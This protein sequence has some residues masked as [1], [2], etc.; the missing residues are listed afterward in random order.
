MF[1][2][3]QLQRAFDE[4]GGTCPAGLFAELEAAYSE[5]GRHYHSTTHVAE[6]LTHF[7][8][9]RTHARAP[10]EIELALWFHDAI[11]DARASDNE[12]RS[13]EW[14]VAALGNAGCPGASVHA[15]ASMILATKS[16]APASDDEALLVDIDL[17]ILGAA[18]EGFERYDAQIR[19]EYEWVPLAQYREA[20]AAVLAGFLA[21]DAIY[22]TDHFRHLEAPARS[23]L[24]AKI[25]ALRT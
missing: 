13:A 1:T 25:E 6:C 7:A 14:A 22:R 20:R 24:A 12:E 4:L 18:P 9:V 21:R 3:P 23:N 17:G 10:A 19:L 11:Y 15:V 2:A 8:A 5:P 16:H